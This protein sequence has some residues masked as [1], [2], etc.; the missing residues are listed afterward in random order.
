[1]GD[2]YFHAVHVHRRAREDDASTVLP[3]VDGGNIP[4]RNALPCDNDGTISLKVGCLAAQDACLIR[5]RLDFEAR[6]HANRQL[7]ASTRE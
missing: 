3:V 5:S 6:L 7:C 1:M 4:G 2:G